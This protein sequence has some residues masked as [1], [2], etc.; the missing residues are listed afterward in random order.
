MEEERKMKRVADSM[1]EQVHLLFPRSM[2]S[3]GRLYGGQLLDWLDEIAGIV[4][5]R[6][7]G[8]NVVTASID[9][10]DF[11]EGAKE[12]DTVVIQ[13]YLTYVGTSS[14]EVRIDSYVEDMKDGRRRLINTAFFV[15]VALDDEGNPCQVPGLILE[16]V[17]QKANWEAGKRRKQ[18]RKERM[19]EGY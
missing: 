7:S 3:A 19:R 18:F 2:N 9:R 12:G 11:K 1:T 4:G 5:K 13:G 6:H 17:S 16:G 14:M 8:C 10:M 15:M